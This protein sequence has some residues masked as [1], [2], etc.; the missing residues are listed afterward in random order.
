MKFIFVFLLLSV[1]Q[2]GFAQLT[3]YTIDGCS[4]CAY[5]VQ[6]LRQNNIAFAEC[7]TSR[8]QQCDDDF[9][10]AVAH[11]QLSS[12][13]MPVITD[14]EQIWYNIKKLNA[15]VNNLVKTYRNKC[16]SP[17]TVEYSSTKPV[18]KSA[19]S[20]TDLSSNPF[21]DI[22][23]A[24][25][26]DDEMNRAYTTLGSVHY[27]TENEKK[28]IYFCNLARLNGKVFAQNIIAP[29]AEKIRETQ[30]SYVTS[31]MADLQNLPANLHVYRPSESLSKVAKIHAEDMGRVG[32]VGHDSSDGT[33][34]FT[35]IKKYNKGGAQAENC[36]YGIQDPLDI[37]IDLLIDEGV[38]SKGHRKN[39]L[40]SAYLF[41]GTGIASHKTYGTNCVMDFS[42]T[43]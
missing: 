3:V 37:V 19:V 5:T 1:S 30:N 18:T 4:R 31:L 6:T 35:R 34:C 20:G 41:I 36:S 28:V 9:A 22:T 21:K 24:G 13:T 23:P 42:D 16:Y 27:L 39:I 33:P 25:F 17:A 32:G 11:L 29:Y 14:G 40:S 8:S 38:S 12:F 10:E 43:E 15:T 7:N 2:I 26:S